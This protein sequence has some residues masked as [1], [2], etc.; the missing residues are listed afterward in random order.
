M[1]YSISNR[2]QTTHLLPTWSKRTLTP[3]RLCLTCQGAR[4]T[5][6]WAQLRRAWSSCAHFSKDIALGTSSRTGESWQPR[7]RT[8]KCATEMG[9]GSADGREPCN[10]NAKSQSQESVSGMSRPP[11]PSRGIGASGGGCA[12]YRPPRAGYSTSRVEGEAF[13]SADQETP[14]KKEGPE[15]TPA[16]SNGRR[17]YAFPDNA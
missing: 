12:Y 7:A 15:S 8:R 17:E 14:R 13:K 6:V 4:T 9:V 1:I 2:L 11:S 10:A 5:T 16:A 3:R